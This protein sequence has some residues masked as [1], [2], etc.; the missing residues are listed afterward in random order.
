MNLR[1]RVN[2]LK[3][4]TGALSWGGASAGY[5]PD[6]CICQ[7]EM[8]PHTHY[9]DTLK[10]AR[11]MKCKGYTPRFPPDSGM[12]TM[13][14]ARDPRAQFPVQFIGVVHLGLTVLAPVFR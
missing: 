3:N 12:P 8:T 1:D 9:E 10:C 7:N 6:A 4:T 5:H 11:C 14:F 13:A 2:R